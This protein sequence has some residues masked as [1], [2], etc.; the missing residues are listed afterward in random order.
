MSKPH[1]QFEPVTLGHLRRETKWL[2]PNARSAVTS[3]SST[4]ASRLS[5]RC[6][7]ALVPALGKSMVCSKCGTKGKIWSVAELY[8]ASPETFWRWRM[9]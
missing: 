7:T 2:H 5:T 8:G 6:P 4:S 1:Q 3:W 9:S